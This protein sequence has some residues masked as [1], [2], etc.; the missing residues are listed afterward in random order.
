MYPCR[1]SVHQR[2]NQAGIPIHD[3]RDALAQMPM[4]SMAVRHAALLARMRI[5]K[6]GMV[7]IEEG[8]EERCGLQVV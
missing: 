4:R 7:A 8:K 5:Y 2:D 1:Q 6:F 3:W